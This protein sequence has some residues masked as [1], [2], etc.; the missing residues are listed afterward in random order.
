MLLNSG[1]SYDV[2]VSVQNFTTVNV[3]AKTM[4]IILYE[5]L[6]SILGFVEKLILHNYYA[7]PSDFLTSYFSLLEARTNTYRGIV[8][9][10]LESVVQKNQKKPSYM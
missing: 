1:T 8:F 10:G 9:L 6:E 7:A 2:H 5:N 4:A 3:G